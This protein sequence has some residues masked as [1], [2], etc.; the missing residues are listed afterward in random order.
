L[1]LINI[2]DFKSGSGMFAS[3]LATFHIRHSIWNVKLPLWIYSVEKLEIQRK[4]NC[5]QS[6]F[7]INAVQFFC[8]SQR[9]ALSRESSDLLCPLVSEK[10]KHVREAKIFSP[11]SEM[12]FFNSIDRTLAFVVKNQA[13]VTRGSQ[14]GPGQ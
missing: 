6:T 5:S 4:P 1:T 13:Y 8:V 7:F 10:M 9:E 3:G 11:L 14:V 12:E 2:E